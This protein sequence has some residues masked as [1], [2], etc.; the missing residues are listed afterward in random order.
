VTG[1]GGSL[2]FAART[3]GAPKEGGRPDVDALI[4]LL[5]CIFS[6]ILH[7]RT[8]VGSRRY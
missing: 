7:L 4:R 5:L 8:R 1:S 6:D 2:L 3:S